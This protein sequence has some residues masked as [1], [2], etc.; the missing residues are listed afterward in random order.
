MA[1][2]LTIGGMSAG[3]LGG[4]N[5][6]GPV[7]TTGL[8]SVG[9]RLSN[10]TLA[11]GDNTFAVPT[12]STSVAIFLGQSPSA[13]VKL[14][15]NLNLIEAG[16]PIAPTQVVSWA[17]FDLVSGVTSV[18]LNASGSLVGVEVDFI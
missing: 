8:N 13:T 14:R 10:L 7:S 15:T 2:T 1:G 4:E 6:I 18:V 3:L 5:V 9:T 11:S 12:G 16:L 17:K